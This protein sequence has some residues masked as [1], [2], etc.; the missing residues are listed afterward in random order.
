MVAVQP[1]VLTDKT[2]LIA[3]AGTRLGAALA[4]ALA[5]RGAMVVLSD[6]D[7]AP[8]LRIAARAPDRIE[9]LPIALD[10]AARIE[11]LGSVWGDEPLDGLIQLQSFAMARTPGRAIQSMLLMARAFAPGLGAARGHVTTLLR[12]AGPD[13]AEECRAAERAQRRLCA[14]LPDMLAARGIRA[15]TLLVPADLARTTPAEVVQPVL[16]LNAPAGRRIHGAEIS[17]ATA[18]PLPPV[19]GLGRDPGGAG[20]ALAD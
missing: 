15:N 12:A 5:A 10:S 17:L 14:V 2:F 8:L 1:V 4:R 11:A 9:P 7:E 16:F 18:D 6:A 20:A 19:P 3:G 13:A